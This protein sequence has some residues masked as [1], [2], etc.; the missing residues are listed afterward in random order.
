MTIV[1]IGRMLPSFISLN[2]FQTLCKYVGNV[3]AYTVDNIEAP[4]GDCV[5]IRIDFFLTLSPKHPHQNKNAF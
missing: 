1:L 4:L 2:I 5:F 3:R